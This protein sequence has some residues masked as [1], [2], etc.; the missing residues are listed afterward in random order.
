[1]QVLRCIV[2]T[3]LLQLGY[4]LV[5]AS[6]HKAYE[7]NLAHHPLQLHTLL[8]PQQYHNELCLYSGMRPSYNAL[9]PC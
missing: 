4:M 1:M 7:D 9:Q 3:L 5:S 2:Q 6:S 8:Q